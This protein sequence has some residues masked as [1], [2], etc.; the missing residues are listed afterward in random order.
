M[1]GVQ[2]YQSFVKRNSTPES[3]PIRSGLYD[4]TVFVKNGDT[5]PPLLYDTIRWR[6]IVFEKN[7]GGSVGTTDTMFWQRYR[8]GYFSSKVDTMKKE[9]V[10]SKFNPAFESFNL[11]TLQYEMPDSNSIILKGKIRNDSVYTVL[12]RSKRH[13]QLTEKQFHWL[14]EYNR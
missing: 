1:G 10:F 7:G 8:R 4:V 14:S 9:I 5:I 12:H 2:S 6:D 3:K 13:F 11:F